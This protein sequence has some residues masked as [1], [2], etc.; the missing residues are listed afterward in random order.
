MS[1]TPM[2]PRVLDTHDLFVKNARRA[3]FEVMCEKGLSQRQLA[4]RMNQTEGQ[5]SRVLHGNETLNFRTFAR[6]CDAVGVRFDLIRV[7]ED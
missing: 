1:R 2:A 3:I 4:T 6:L 7:E 5:I